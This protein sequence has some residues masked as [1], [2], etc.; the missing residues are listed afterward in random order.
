[1]SSNVPAL[2]TG[3]V[4]EGEE[5]R[6]ARCGRQVMDGRDTRLVRRF[7][8]PSAL[9]L[10][11]EGESECLRLEVDASAILLLSRT[12]N[13]GQGSRHSRDRRSWSPA[14]PSQKNTCAVLALPPRSGLKTSPICQRPAWAR[15]RH[16]HGAD[17]G[18]SDLC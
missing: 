18:A 8:L 11:A 5:W 13:D 15:G 6:S 7:F 16:S 9:G 2:E 14:R 4:T 10:S 17:I 12:G 1:M 3:P